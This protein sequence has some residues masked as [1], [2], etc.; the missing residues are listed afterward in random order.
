MITKLVSVFLVFFSGSISWGAS[1]SYELLSIKK[2][3]SDKGFYSAFKNTAHAAPVEIH[4][5]V[6]NG[7]DGRDYF[8][9]PITI[10]VG[11]KKKCVFKDGGIYSA[12]YLSNSG[13]HLLTKEYSGSCGEFR[14]FDIE[15]CKVDS[16]V[17]TYCGSATLEE[18]QRLHSEPYCEPLD[19]GKKLS[20]CSSAKVFSVAPGC[21]LKFEA[22]QSL[23]LAEKMLGVRLPLTGSH[24][25]I[26][27]GPGRAEIV[28]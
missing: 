28:K 24:K 15:N 6:E 20:S 4:I 25:V 14:V 8:D 26:G 13:T 7:Q 11:G 3:D 9:G 27:I 12:F 17:A 2:R 5:Q 16:S 22:S 23:R 1:C 19:P 18:G 10:S 21:K